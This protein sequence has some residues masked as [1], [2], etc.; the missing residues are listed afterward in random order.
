V[1]TVSMFAKIGGCTSATV[2]RFE[3]YP[4]ARACPETRFGIGCDRHANRLPPSV[5]MPT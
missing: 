1:I 3:I 2:S 5:K 4:D